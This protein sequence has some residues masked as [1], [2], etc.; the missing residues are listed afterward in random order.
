MQRRH[1][2]GRARAGRRAA[3]AGRIR[4][5]A[6]AQRS[7]KPTGLNTLGPAAHGELLLLNDV[8]QPLSPN[9]IR[10]LATALQDPTVGCATGNLVLIGNA[11][12]GVYWRYENW[13]RRQESAF[14]AWWA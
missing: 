12:S 10:A 8:R 1:R 2:G 7:G 6:S 4:V 11:G 3:A 13:I 14:R 9:A 5:F